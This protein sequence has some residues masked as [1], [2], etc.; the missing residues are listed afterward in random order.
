MIKVVKNIVNHK[1]PLWNKTEPH[2]ITTNNNS[3][4]ITQIAYF[5]REGF[6]LSSGI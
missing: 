5:L 2:Q 6:G 3:Y 1:Q 4:L